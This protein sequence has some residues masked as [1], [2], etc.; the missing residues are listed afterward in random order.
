MSD[1]LDK[2]KETSKKVIKKKDDVITEQYKFNSTGFEMITDIPSESSIKEKIKGDLIID[3]PTSPL[4]K[5]NKSIDL[6]K[7]IESL[8]IKID[9]KIMKSNKELYESIIKELKQYSLC[10]NGDII[11][12]SSID[13]SKDYPLK[14]ENDYFV[15]YGKK[16]SYN[17]LKIQKN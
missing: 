10:L 11:Y 15:L 8:S 5:S 14:F 13:K 9:K 2:N 16:Y 4:K 3:M 1:E 17:G 12:N 6:D 7:K